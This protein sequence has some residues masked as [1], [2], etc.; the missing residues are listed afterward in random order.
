[1]KTM[2]A[3]TSNKQAD[4]AGPGIGDYIELEK[5]LPSDYRSLLTVERNPASDLPGKTVHRR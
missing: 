2:S 4:L 1:M 5:I 3:V